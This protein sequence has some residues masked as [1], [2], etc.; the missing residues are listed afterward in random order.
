MKNRDYITRLHLI[1]EILAWV[2]LLVSLII[3]VVGAVT[4]EGPIP[5]HFDGKGNPNSYGS[6]ASLLLLPAIVIIALGSVSFIA[7][8]LDPSVWNMPFKVNPLRKGIVYRDMMSMIFIMELLIAGLA[9][10]ITMSIFFQRTGSVGWVTGIFVGV[11]FL[12]IIVWSAIAY[13][14]NRM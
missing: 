13:R 1:L 7:H 9:L 11:L 4:M 10:F 5:I 8:F 6:P 12:D 3:A 2:L 14:H